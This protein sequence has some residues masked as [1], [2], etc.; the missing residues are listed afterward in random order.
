MAPL[1]LARG[2]GQVGAF[3]K[4]GPTLALGEAAAT[5]TNPLHRRGGDV[6]NHVTDLVLGAGAL[7]AGVWAG[8]LL[9]R[10]DAAARHLLH[11]GRL[12]VGVQHLVL[13]EVVVYC[14][15]NGGR[16]SAIGCGG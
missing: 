4:A 5:A 14:R 7:A 12:K 10:E 15:R 6:V 11:N 13:G 3:P 9:H 8:L 2:V 1:T 16:L